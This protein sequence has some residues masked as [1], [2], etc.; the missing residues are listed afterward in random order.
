M[1]F[2][3]LGPD[4]RIV[5]AYFVKVRKAAAQAKKEGQ[6]IVPDTYLL[7]DTRVRIQFEMVHF[8]EAVNIPTLE[9]ETRS[10]RNN[11]YF[12]QFDYQR[13][14]RTTSKR[15]S[16]SH[17]MYVG[18]RNVRLG[19]IPAL[20]TH[21]VSLFRGQRNTR[22]PIHRL[23]LGGDPWKITEADKASIVQSYLNDTFFPLLLRVR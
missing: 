7:L 14:S 22:A 20:S 12:E 11:Q 13:R 21:A 10:C 18:V 17:F 6:R 19:V 5:V 23:L 16:S 8:A 3:S 1:K 15:C 2:D 9:Y 4:F